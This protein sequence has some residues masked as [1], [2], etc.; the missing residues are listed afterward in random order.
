M[1]IHDRTWPTF[2]RELL[3]AR[4]RLRLPDEIGLALRDHRRRLGLS[5]RAYAATRGLSTNH[6]ARLEADADSCRLQD[7]LHALAGTGFQL[8]LGAAALPPPDSPDP[9][10][11][12]SEGRPPPV[13]RTYWA[14]TELLARV[15][16]GGRR[17]PGHRVTR[18]V[19]T[20]PPWWW[21]AESTRS[22]VVG[23][24]WYAP[25]HDLPIVPADAHP[26]A[27]SGAAPSS[28]SADPLPVADGVGQEAPSR[29]GAA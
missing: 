2:A 25:V 5:Q 14:R 18:Q 29:R 19:L 23:P 16:G 4:D 9:G 24:T 10:G 11:T 3:A 27:F 7:V 20:P 1:D 6:L 15:R 12:V 13:P 22:G 26:G 21:Y 28:A 17:F 8:Y